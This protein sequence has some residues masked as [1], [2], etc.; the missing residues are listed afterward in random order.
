[1]SRDIVKQIAVEAT[2]H[3]PRGRPLIIGVTGQDASGK[4][5]L[6][7]ELHAYL[8][9]VGYQTV[10]V[11]VDDFHR[12]KNQRYDPDL[13]EHD[14]YLQK[15][16]DFDSL[17]EA[18]LRP[19]RM[20][21]EV[22][23]TLTHLD[24]P[25][26]SYT[27][28]RHY[29]AGPGSIVVVEG[30][31]L[32]RPDTRRYLDYIVYVHTDAE[33]IRDR[34]YL[35]DVPEQGADVMRKYESKYLRAQRIHLDKN[36]PQ[37]HADIVV[38]NTVWRRARALPFSSTVE[39]L[40]NDARPVAMLFDLWETLVP[41]PREEKRRAFFATAE[42]L[43]EDPRLLRPAWESTRRQRETGDLKVYIHRLGNEL[44]RNWRPVAIEEAMRVRQRIHGRLFK[45]A[46]ETVVPALR[47]LRSAGAALGLVSNCTSDVR[48]MLTESG[49]LEEFEAVGL[50]AELGVMKPDVRIYQA[51]T[52]LLGEEN[53]QICYI[54]DGSD[55][56]LAGASQAGLHPVR[57]NR[58][59]NAAWPG[60][61]A[62]SLEEI[63]AAY[64]R[65]TSSRKTEEQG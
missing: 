6:G 12:P 13:A 21:G 2:A 56:E 40:F 64:E 54:G 24:L 26:D 59:D 58:L 57:L 42:I 60:S 1:M 4:S 25:S 16:F 50:S 53:M 8:S 61:A 36:P 44:G 47:T 9:D 18:I 55:A 14:A 17:I 34:A 46:A 33:T 27:R 63:V 30:V 19:A 31:F 29:F 11:H 20:R 51:V 15:S 23:A 22:D 3:R 48:A 39:K 10:L 45:V 37:R 62:T 35:R 38:D 49:L 52:R 32:L 41:F 28:Q 7:E 43:G 5:F 65:T